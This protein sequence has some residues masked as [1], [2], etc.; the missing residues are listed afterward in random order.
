MQI[1]T[2]FN[3]YGGI[4]FPDMAYV[5]YIQGSD[6]EDPCEYGATPEEAIQKLKETLEAA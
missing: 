3:N 1:E 4:L 6:G 5:A 2:S